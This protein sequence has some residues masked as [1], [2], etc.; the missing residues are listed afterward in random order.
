MEEIWKDIEDYPN[1]QVSS[2]GRV[3]V[4]NYQHTDK[5][6]ILTPVPRRRGYLGIRLT[7]DNKRKIF[8]IHRL[9][10][11]AFI[12][13]P[14]NLPQV[15]HVDEDKTNNC[16]DNLEWC[17]AKY[18]NAYGTRIERIS[19]TLK[20]HN[21]SEETKK[22]ISNSLSKPILQFDTKENFITKWKSAS[23]VER[24]L[25]I[26]GCQIAGCCKG[27]KRYKTAGGYKWGYAEYYERIPF[28]VF[29]LEIYRKKVA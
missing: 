7:K 22:K 18:N 4:I 12:P 27:K 1:Y 15:N 10:A 23:D 6:K 20:G 13:N 16:V 2:M 28:K 9:V 25:G 11:V 19:N 29:D 5:E 21:V 3:K 14:N 8:Q 17:D 26:K 24:K